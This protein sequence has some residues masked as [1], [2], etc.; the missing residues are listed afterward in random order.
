M[1]NAFYAAYRR[2]RDGN[3]ELVAVS[4]SPH[5]TLTGEAT[6][7]LVMVKVPR[8]EFAQQTMTPEE[9]GTADVLRYS[10]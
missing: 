4:L 5:L 3:Y 9:M 10:Q 1:A 6:G 8:P 7:A 2:R